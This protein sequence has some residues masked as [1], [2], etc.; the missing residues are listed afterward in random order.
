MNIWRQLILIG[1]WLAATSSFALNPGVGMDCERHYCAAVVDAGSSGSRIHWYSYDLDRQHS[2]IHI[3]EAY[4]KKIKPGLSSIAHDSASVAG[5]MDQL[6]SEFSQ[7]G[8]PVYLY[9]TAG[10]RLLPSDKPVLLI[11]NK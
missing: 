4:S 3:H 1:M 8:V 7:S 11:T 2:P 6:T 10:M 9:A 5:Y